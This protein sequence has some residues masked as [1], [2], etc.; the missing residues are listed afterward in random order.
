MHRGSSKGAGV[1]RP[2]SET[3]P[4]SA[5]PP[6]QVLVRVARGRPG[7]E[8]ALSLPSGARVR[9]AVRAVGHSSEGVAVL[10]GELPVPLDEPLRDGMRLTVVP[11]Y[12]GG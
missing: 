1:L 12:S 7:A 4:L 10:V 9:D 6:L 3:L 11:T 2:V 5:S 8:V